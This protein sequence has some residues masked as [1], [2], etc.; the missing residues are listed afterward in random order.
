MVSASIETSAKSMRA[1]SDILRTGFEYNII[2][3]L[4]L[5]LDWQQHECPDYKIPPVGNANGNLQQISS[6]SFLRMRFERNVYK[7]IF[8]VPDYFSEKVL[9]VTR[10]MNCHVN[11]ISC[12]TRKLKLTK[13]KI[14]PIESANEPTV[15]GLEYM[16]D[17]YI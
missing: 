7:N 17:D 8:L 15:K 12:I 4:A 14:P 11:S 1:I 10:F 3:R 6:V 2:H 16:E 9:I 13:G 5:P